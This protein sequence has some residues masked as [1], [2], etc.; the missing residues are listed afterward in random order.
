M[1]EALQI[2]RDVA[3]ALDYAHGQGVI[4]RDIKPENIL[5][6]GGQRAGRRLR[7]RAGAA[8]GRAASGSTETGH[9]VGTPA[10]MSPEQAGGERSVDGRSDVYSLGCVL[11][12]MLAGE[13][14]YTGPT[15][16]PSSPSASAIRCPRS[17][18]CG[19]R[20]RSGWSEAVTK[21]LAPVAADRFA[22]AAEFVR[23]LAA[24]DCARRGRRRRL[25]R[26]RV[27]STR[28][29]L[30]LGLV[31]A[32]GLAVAAGGVLW[33]QSQPGGSASGPT[34]LAVL[35][36]ENQGAPEDDYFADGMTDAVRGKLSALPALQVIARQSSAEYKK[37]TK[38]LKQIGRE[39]G[40]QYLLTATVRWEKSGGASRV[41]VSPE[42]VQVST[43]STK[44]QQPFD[45]A[46]TDVFQVQATDRGTGRRGARRGARGEGEADA[47]READA[48][49]R[50]L[51]CLSPSG[52][53]RQ[54][55]GR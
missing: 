17:G 2:A 23:A 8:A 28:R 6:I 53:G 46:M 22:T 14:P 31:A 34:R 9:G 45:A 50:G 35:P 7:H 29:S 33:Q 21:A 48:E 26:Q 39:L 36:F 20:C 11:Y 47:G 4:H 27:R 3:E 40:V 41:Q 49:P 5:L 54:I 15:P 51:R 16:R 44:W 38:S 24:L 32:L 25:G 1:D 52:G 13:P 10:Y 18:G 42:L 12:E 37:S 55:A 19:R 43:A 30:A